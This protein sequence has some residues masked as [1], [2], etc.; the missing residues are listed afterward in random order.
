MIGI[1]ES[2]GAAFAMLALLASGFTIAA[3]FAVGRATNAAPVSREKGIRVPVTV[4]KPL[5]HAE[6]GLKE[7]LKSFFRQ[8]YGGPIQIIFGASD[9]DDPALEVVNSLR[10]AFPDVDVAVIAGAKRIGTNPKVANL[11][12]LATAARHEL[13]ILSDS[14]IRVPPDYVRK[15]VAEMEK[16][17]VGAVSLLYSGKALGNVWSRLAAMNI[18][19]H[20]Q[21][22]ARLGM[23]LGLARPCFGSTIAFR[24]Y[25]LAEIGG[26]ESFANV[27]ADDYEIGRAIRGRGYEISV[28]ESLIV[29]HVC[30][31]TSASALLRQELRWARTNFVLA[32]A[33]YTGSVVTYP[34]P[35]A[36]LAL[37]FQG[38]STMA[39]AA[40]ACALA[41][42]LYLVFKSGR[43]LG[44]HADYFWLLPLR[45]VLSFVVYLAA[46]FG[47]T[48]EWRG[49]RFST[50]TDGALA[51]V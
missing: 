21:P 41:S 11:A 23:A 49:H 33:G 42:R 6:P 46:F 18:D 32:K 22:N 45:D 3:A 2:I 51:P 24:R 43:R 13:L 27:L 19:C 30:S 26:F 48:V 16:P 39:V 37:L 20:F 25:T 50:G 34:L 36:L 15:I 4:I 14:D 10:R 5:H 12:N 29:E 44:W 38:F 40:L 31:Q 35:I 17:G 8:D 1:H 7:S 47:R 9:P 28:P